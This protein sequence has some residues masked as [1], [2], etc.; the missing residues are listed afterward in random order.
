[1]NKDPDYIQVSLDP[2]IVRPR[3]P[4]N[5][6]SPPNSRTPDEGAAPRI[7]LRRGRPAGLVWNKQILVIAAAAGTL[8]VIACLA[9]YVSY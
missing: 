9:I 4:P 7:P 8:L 6:G 5:P 3:R 2:T 1:M